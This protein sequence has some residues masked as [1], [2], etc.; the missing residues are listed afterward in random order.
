MELPKNV[1]AKSGSKFG[2][3][4]G[5]CQNGSS[6]SSRS[7]VEVAKE[8]Q[9]VGQNG[10]VDTEDIWYGEQEPIWYVQEPK[11]EPEFGK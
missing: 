6:S 2:D 5:D 11:C 10:S 1:E 9:S 3:G 8:I 7:W 4:S